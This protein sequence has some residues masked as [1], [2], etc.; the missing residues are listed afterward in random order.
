M[1]RF[2]FLNCILSVFLLS[3]CA[4]MPMGKPS[5]W[6]QRD[7]LET[8][9]FV[10]QKM[11]SVDEAIGAIKNLQ[12]NFVEWKAGIN[13]SNLEVDP[14]GM[15]AKWVWTETSQQTAY[16][17]SYGG[18]FLGS[19]YV[20]VYGG[21]YQTQTYSQAQNGMFI[22]PFNEIKSFDLWHMPTLP[23]TFKWGLVVRVK[24]APPVM[25]RVSDE[26]SLV[27]LA[28]AISTIA[29]E[30]GAGFLKF[31]LGCT[32]QPLTPQQS[33]IMGLVPNTGLLVV[34][35]VKNS[36]AEKSGIRFLD[37]LLEFD[38]IPLKEGKDLIN[39]VQGAYKAG[40]KSAPVKFIR[41]ENVSQPVINPQT[42]KV[43]R[44]EIIEQ[45]IEKNIDV[46]LVN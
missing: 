21:S 34:R 46:N 22:I 9:Y 5:T 3:G 1:R 16:V 13:F 10:P 27:K 8:L 4:T 35:V 39:A 41:R 45:K 2:K 28:N 18:M 29:M 36:P 33:E 23:K 12:Q 20:P 6:P 26:A 15:R 7:N 19:T 40:K 11:A 38:R 37:V 42:Q 44:T 30:R 25:L 24:N 43:L 17:P 14:F 31:W 32:V